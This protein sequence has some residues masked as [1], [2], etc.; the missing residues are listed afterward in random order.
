MFENSPGVF[1]VSA[2][3]LHGIQRKQEQLRMTKKDNLW[4]KNCRFM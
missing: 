2:E 3:M 4:I 1:N